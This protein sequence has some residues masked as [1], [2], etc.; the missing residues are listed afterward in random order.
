MKTIAIVR[1]LFV[2][3]SFFIAGAAMADSCKDT[4]ASKKLAGAALTSFMTKCSEGRA[5]EL[6]HPGR[7]QEARRRGQDQLHQEVR[8]GRDRLVSRRS[9]YRADAR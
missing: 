7:R 5:G 9:T 6:R 2:L 8:S 1:A 3:A 4:A